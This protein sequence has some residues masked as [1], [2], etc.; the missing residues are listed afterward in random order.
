MEHV[1]DIIK[2]F[3]DDMSVMRQ[4][5]ETQKQLDELQQHLCTVDIPFTIPEKPNETN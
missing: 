5:D 3:M 1:K 4:I 2:R